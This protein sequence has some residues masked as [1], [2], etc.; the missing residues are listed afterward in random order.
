M[1]RRLIIINKINVEYSEEI[2]WGVLYELGNCSN[3]FNY[4]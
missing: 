4:R 2:V 3:S 1:K